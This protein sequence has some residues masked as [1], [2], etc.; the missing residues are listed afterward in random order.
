MSKQEFERKQ[1][2]D[3]H[4]SEAE[5][6]LRA[7]AGVSAAEWGRPLAEG[8]WTIGQLTEHLALSYETALDAL[9]GG[10]GMK[11]VLPWWKTQFL[12]WTVLPRILAGRGFPEGAPAPRELRPGKE[13]LARETAMARLEERIASAERGLAA[14]APDMRFSHAYFGW[15]RPEQILGVQA[16]HLAHHRRQLEAASARLDA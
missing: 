8:K 4:R 7:L 1:A 13:P 15:L 6:L 2:S 11:Q 10:R 14:A 16:A 9:A 12:R 5:S 3:W